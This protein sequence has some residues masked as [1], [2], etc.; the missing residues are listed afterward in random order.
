MYLGNSGTG[1]RLLT[2]L[3]AS[4]GIKAVLTGDKSLSSRPM[5]RIIQPLELMN[6]SVESQKG[7]LPLKIKKDKKKFLFQ[8]TMS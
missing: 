5:K 3:L 7:G 8:L 4:S 1:V 2:G 6:L